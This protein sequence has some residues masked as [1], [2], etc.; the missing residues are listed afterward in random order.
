MLL[1]RYVFPFYLS[2]LL[3]LIGLKTYGL[4]FQKTQEPRLINNSHRFDREMGY[5]FKEKKQDISSSYF[6]LRYLEASQGQ[7]EAYKV[8]YQVFHQV[9][10]E[11]GIQGVANFHS[12]GLDFLPFDE[13]VYFQTRKMV[14]Q[15][16]FKEAH[17]YLLKNENIFTKHPGILLFYATTEYEMGNKSKAMNLYNECL[18]QKEKFNTPYYNKL[19][20]YQAV[21]DQCLLG[22][23]RLHY[24]L[25]EYKD[26]YEFYGKLNQ[27]SIYYPSSLVEMAWTA[28]RVGRLD[29]TLGYAIAFESPAL[30]PYYNGEI[31]ILVALSMVRTCQWDYAFGAM[32]DLHVKTDQYLNALK[33]AAK[34]LNENI[35]SYIQRGEVDSTLSNSLIG[36]HFQSPIWITQ[37]KVILKAYDDLLQLDPKHPFYENL[38]EYLNHIITQRTK[39]LRDYLGYRLK[40]QFE[41]LKG[42]KINADKIEMELLAKMRK[43]LYGQNQ[44]LGNVMGVQK[45]Q[46]LSSNFDQKWSFKGEFWK[47]EIE[48]L[49]FPIKDNCEQGDS[50]AL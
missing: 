23:A 14:Y 39:S 41:I 13:L 1:E 37:R 38:K 49:S 16:N 15:N 31:E 18:K 48:E 30:K 42:F 32:K 22:K 24:D 40:H 45:T 27:T 3:S 11:L 50:D 29:K 19:Y 43:S 21:V 12:Q 33:E 17:E 25:E 28:Y 20:D 4:N 6:F 26:A 9:V 47:D 7:K 44:E 34:N 46:S 10:R 8:R 35:K 5:N 2:L 36:K